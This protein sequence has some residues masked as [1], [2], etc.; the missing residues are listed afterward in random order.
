MKLKVALGVFVWS[1]L[2]SVMHIQLNIGWG[3]VSDRIAVMRGQ[4]RAELL[5]GF[6]PV[7]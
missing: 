2:I 1:L 4:Q 6:L 3:A 5:V 7:T